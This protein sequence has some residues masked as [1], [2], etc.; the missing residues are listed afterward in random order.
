MWAR[1]DLSE[2]GLGRALV[3]EGE[4]G[5]RAVLSAWGEAWILS[6]HRGLGQVL[7]AGTLGERLADGGWGVP[8]EGDLGWLG[9]A[10]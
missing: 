9:D 10:A 7:D 1:S 4:D 2:V 3:T 5:A 8:S 6:D